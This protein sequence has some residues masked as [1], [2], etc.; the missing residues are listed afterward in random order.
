VIVLDSSFL[1]AYHNERD[2]HHITASQLMD[3]FLKGAGGKGLLLEYVFLEVV[4]V[5]LK[6]RDVT[7]AAK[8]G[9]IL[10]EAEELEFVPCSDIFLETVEHFS[11]QLGTR[12]SFADSAI[13]DIARKRAAGRI[14]SFDE[15][16]GNIS[17]LQIN[18]AT[19]PL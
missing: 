10:L 1:V 17:G 14:L 2:A 9:A 4:T 6:R 7:T 5:L 13:A 16:F 3:Q 11:R 18:P 19:A 15:E 12:L 8:V